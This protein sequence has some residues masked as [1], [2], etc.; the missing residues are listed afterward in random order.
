MEEIILHH[1][2]Q[3]PV[4]EKVRIG[5]GI[6]G[7]AWRSVIIPRVPPKPDLMPLTGGYRRTPVLQAGADIY[8]DSQCILRELERRF[9]EPSFYPP[10]GA[11]MPWGV[12]RW[13]DGELLDLAVKVVLG[14]APENLPKDFAADRG[15]LYFGPDW[16]LDKIHADLPH[17]LAQLRA[18]L[19]WLDQRLA[20]GRDFILGPQPSLPDA[21]AYYLVWF[22]R[23][24]WEGGPALLSEFAALEAWEARVGAIGHG[25][26]SELS[27]PEALEIARAA[28]PQTPEQGDP[29]DPQALTPGMKVSLVPDVDG[30]D[31]AVEGTVRY[32]DRESIAILREEERVGRVC[33][34]FPRVGYRMTVL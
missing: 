9:P 5:L 7:L 8:C 20:T 28:E 13:T 25:E 31:P 24:R 18:Q 34:H 1:Y 12:S 32:A 29:K 30:G 3:S 6:K 14:A 2:P 4:T 16:N 15:R 23:G 33:I 10:G 11:G 27:A 17:V 22:L 26:P 21:L 19:G